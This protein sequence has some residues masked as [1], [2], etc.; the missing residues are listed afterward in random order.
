MHENYKIVATLLPVCHKDK[1]EYI[2]MSVISI[3]T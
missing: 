2:K 3:L 1:V